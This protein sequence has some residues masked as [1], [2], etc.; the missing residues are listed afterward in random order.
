MYTTDALEYLL[1][2]RYGW[3]REQV[4]AWL[5]EITTDTAPWTPDFS[6]EFPRRDRNFYI[7]GS[8]EL[9]MEGGYLEWFLRG[10]TS[11]VF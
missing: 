11:G 10:P 8:R 7:T 1:V 9:E 6:T 2:S 4:R 3:S 5:L